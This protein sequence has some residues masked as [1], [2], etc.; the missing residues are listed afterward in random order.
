M[1]S[2]I[3]EVEAF[4]AVQPEDGPV[5]LRL[6]L[7]F[8]GSIE[9]DVPCL[10][11][12]RG[13]DERVFAPIA[14]SITGEATPGRSW[15]AAFAVPRELALDIQ[16]RFALDIG[17]LVDL[18]APTH[19]PLSAAPARAEPEHIP[20][21][22]IERERARADRAWEAMRAANRRVTE[23]DRR[24]TAAEARAEAARERGDGLARQLEA[25]RSTAW[26]LAALAAEVPRL[27]RELD[28]SGSATMTADERAETARRIASLTTRGERESERAQALALE[29]DQASTRVDLVVAELERTRAAQLEA[30]SRAEGLETRI[31]D[32]RDQL[33]TREE[34]LAFMRSAE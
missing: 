29:L 11:L 34:E 33:R 23:L 19:R 28:G 21:D 25:A 5:L 17:G 2:A 10:V 3:F 30:A 1:T 31:G 27:R 32:L 14:G 15:Q 16:A 7:A 12:A 13:E 26:R 24:L 9:A 8:Q 20:T 18:P 4:Q 22:A 6:R